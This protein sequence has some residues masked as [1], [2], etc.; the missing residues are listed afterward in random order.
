MFFRL[1][2][3]DKRGGFHSEQGSVERLMKKLETLRRPADLWLVNEQSVKIETI[4][5]CEE[6]DG[7][8]DDKRIKWQWWYDSTASEKE[9]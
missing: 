1:E 4:G 5:G 9:G 8:Q 6:A 7:Y 3:T 2:W